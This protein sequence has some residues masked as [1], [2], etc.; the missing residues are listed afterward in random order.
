MKKTI[1]KVQ[2]LECTPHFGCDM[3]PTKNANLVFVFLKN[4]FENDLELPLILIFF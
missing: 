1:L 2:T 3:F 4:H